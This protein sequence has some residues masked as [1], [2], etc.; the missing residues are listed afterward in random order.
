MATFFPVGGVLVI[1]TLL[2]P[3]S[4][5]LG[6][7]PAMMTLERAFPIDHRVHELSQLR[8]RD[9]IRHGRMLQSSNGG[10]VIDFPIGGTFNPFLVGYSINSICILEKNNQV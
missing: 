4:V 10:G 6:G 9:R 8:A 2:L 7:F 3:V 1:A 5:V